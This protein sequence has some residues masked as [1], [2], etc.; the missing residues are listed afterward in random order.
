MEM[1]EVDMWTY[2]FLQEGSFGVDAE[3]L[4]NK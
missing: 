3:Y 1:H 4:K 2:W